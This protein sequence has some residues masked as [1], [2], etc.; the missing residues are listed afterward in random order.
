MKKI[1]SRFLIAL[2]LAAPAVTINSCVE[3]DAPTYAYSTA[4]MEGPWRWETE[5]G[6]AGADYYEITISQVSETKIKIN[7]FQ[8][9]GSVVL[10]LS[11]MSSAGANVSFEGQLSS[12]FVI[13][14]G[15]GR[16]S[17]GYQSMELSYE[18]YEA[19]DEDFENPD[20]IEVKLTKGQAISKKAT[21][22]LNYE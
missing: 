2:A 22:Q 20:K 18:V 19:D 16:I 21:A 9:I 7:N 11:E 15:K 12:A 4:D 5:S 14:N 10:E 17:N 8:G 3:E 1:L 13:K 6:D